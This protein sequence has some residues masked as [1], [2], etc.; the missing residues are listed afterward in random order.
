MNLG[1]R[2]LSRVHPWL[3]EATSIVYTGKI[4]LNVLHETVNFIQINESNS[5]DE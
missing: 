1:V 4:L 5:S 2:F 3:M